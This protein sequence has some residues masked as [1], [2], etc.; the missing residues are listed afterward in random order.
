MVNCKGSE[1]QIILFII[2]RIM[3][4]VISFYIYIFDSFFGKKFSLFQHVT[5]LSRSNKII[6]I[7]K[8]FENMMNLTV[9]FD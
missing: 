9:F 1:K 3:K 8:S 4:S 7:S 5:F 2:I 6:D